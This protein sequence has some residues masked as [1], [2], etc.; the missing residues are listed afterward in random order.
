MNRLNKNSRFRA[1]TDEISNNYILNW[2][3]ILKFKKK[4]KNGSYFQYCFL[5][6]FYYIEINNFFAK[7]IKNIK[8]K[9]KNQENA[10]KWKM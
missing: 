8:I 9:Y 7:D 2:K 1:N 10:I 4:K 6:L 3:W 5:L